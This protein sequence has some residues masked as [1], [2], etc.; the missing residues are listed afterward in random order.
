M[1]AHGRCYASPMGWHRDEYVPIQEEI[2]SLGGTLG[3]FDESM[4]MYCELEKLV[5]LFCL[6]FFFCFSSFVSVS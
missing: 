3:A 6:L 1:L 4:H 2:V 5:F